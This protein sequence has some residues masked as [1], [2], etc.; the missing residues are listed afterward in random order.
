MKLC[1][2]DYI[3]KCIIGVFDHEKTQKLPLK[4][5]IEM[6]FNASITGFADNIDNTIDYTYVTKEI[7]HSLGNR[8]FNLIETVGYEILKIVDAMPQVK[9]AKVSVKKIGIPYGSAYAMFECSSAD[10]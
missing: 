5:C 8:E 9:G 7:E 2:K 10:L 3:F 6:E 1:I 4:I